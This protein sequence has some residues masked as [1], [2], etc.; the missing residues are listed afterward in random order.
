MGIF[1][2]VV[3]LL[4]SVAYAVL[5]AFGSPPAGI[6]TVIILVLLGIGWNSLGIGILGEYLGRTY[7]EVKRRPLYVVQESANLHVPA[8]P[9]SLEIVQRSASSHDLER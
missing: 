4:A 5:F 1:L 7:G 6:T 8:Q 2:T 3:S 9:P